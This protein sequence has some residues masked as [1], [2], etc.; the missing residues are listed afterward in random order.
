MLEL[1]RHALP[2]TAEGDPLSVM[3][4]AVVRTHMFRREML[5]AL[6]SL[7]EMEEVTG[8]VAGADV[9]VSMLNMCAAKPAEVLTRELEEVWSQIEVG[10]N[11]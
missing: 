1:V 9:L 8:R 2:S 7:A 11:A 4:L 6:R 3:H 5:P 10:P